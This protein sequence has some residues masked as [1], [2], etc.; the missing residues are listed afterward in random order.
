MLCPKLSTSQMKAK[1]K[2]EEEDEE[3]RAASVSQLAAAALQN[4]ATVAASLIQRRVRVRAP[5]LGLFGRQRG[6]ETPLR[7]NELRDGEES[8]RKSDSLDA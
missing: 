8:K 2:V 4:T 3:T 5:G 7:A 6:R 1:I